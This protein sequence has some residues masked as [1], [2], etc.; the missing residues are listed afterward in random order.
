RCSVVS[1]AVSDVV[2]H[3]EHAFELEIV[4]DLSAS[5]GWVEGDA[6]NYDAALG[7]YPDDVVEFIGRTQQKKWAKLV[8]LAGSEAKARQS[9]LT[10][11][12][13]QLDKRGTIAML[14]RGSTE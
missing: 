3:T 14:R 10:R 12:A 2:D 6:K 11:L 1:G 4:A 5:G 7:L 13:D 8:S 9:L